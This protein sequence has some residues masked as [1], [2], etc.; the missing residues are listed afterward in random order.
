MDCEKYAKCMIDS[1]LGQLPPSREAEVIAH[2]SDCAACRQAFERAKQAAELVD[3]GMELLVEGEPS[4]QFAARLRARMAEEPRIGSFWARQFPIA[5]GVL[6][7]VSV[8]AVVAMTYRERVTYR[9]S[10]PSV[11]SLASGATS[12]VGA[13]ARPFVALRTLRPRV[14][15][16]HMRISMAARPEVLVEPG[17]MAAL[18]RFYEASRREQAAGARATTVRDDSD[19]P[20]NIEPMA[21]KPLEV[22]PIDMPAVSDF[23]DAWPG[24]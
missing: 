4:P 5:A 12:S 2:M 16:S 22:E 6:L 23:T 15:R 14:S 1:A 24:F 20:M 17:Q 13:G 10:E 8:V 9:R 11:A 21:A 19:Q 7:F 18:D 3:R